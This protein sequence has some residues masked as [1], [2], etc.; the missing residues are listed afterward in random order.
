[1]F[2]KMENGIIDQKYSFLGHKV[3]GL[4]FPFRTK[5]VC[6][7]A[8]ACA[9]TCT[10]VSVTQILVFCFLNIF[11]TI[12]RILIIVNLFKLSILQFFSDCLICYQDI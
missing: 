1:M 10:C 4:I 11:E 9:C 3:L 7:R 5:F 12:L 6:M 2:L 8:C